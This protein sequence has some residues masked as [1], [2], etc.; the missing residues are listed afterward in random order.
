MYCIMVSI[1]HQV[2]QFLLKLIFLLSGGLK[3]LGVWE[4]IYEGPLNAQVI[5]ED[6]FFEDYSILKG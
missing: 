6:H 3:I 5:D 4:K 2:A 1:L